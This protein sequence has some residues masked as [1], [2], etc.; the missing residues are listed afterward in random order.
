M[1][2]PGVALDPQPAPALPA[3]DQ[4][5]GRAV[6]VEQDRAVAVALDVR[7]RRLPD[8][9]VGDGHADERI[10]VQ[11]ELDIRGRD[12]VHEPGL[13]LD[14]GVLVDVGQLDD[15]AVVARRPHAGDVD[16]REGRQ[17]FL[18]RFLVLASDVDD[19]VDPVVGIEQGR[20]RGDRVEGAAVLLEDLAAMGDDPVTRNGSEHR[21]ATVSRHDHS[22]DFS[23]R[24]PSS[25]SSMGIEHPRCP[26]VSPR[27][28]P[29]SR[30][31]PGAG[32]APPDG[33]DQVTRRRRG[34]DEALASYR[35]PGQTRECAVARSRWAPSTRD[36][37][38][39]QPRCR[40][41]G[42][43]A[44][45]CGGAARVEPLLQVHEVAV[46]RV[47]RGH[48]RRLRVEDPS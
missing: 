24:E 8:L 4:R 12:R 29:T 16:V 5:A 3:D 9:V 1:G 44:T 35:D 47:E 22:P 23:T 42:T 14:A 26:I 39:L 46:P 20:Q 17:Q 18:D 25:S 6:R 36:G 15:G 19:R 48:G 10:G 13:L 40:A 30:V 11:R 37:A 21:D 34:L 32:H 7:Q 38:P 33:T 27:A 31:R 28:F 43:A 2:Q 41:P 45:R